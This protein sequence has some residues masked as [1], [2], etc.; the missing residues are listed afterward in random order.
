MR[1]LV[2]GVGL[3]G[4]DVRN[5][6]RD[7]EVTHDSPSDPMG[8]DCVVVVVASRPALAVAHDLDRSG[9]AFLPVWGHHGRLQIGPLVAP[10]GPCFECFEQRERQHASELAVHDAITSHWLRAVVPAPTEQLRALRKIA[11][12][13]I[14][15][16]KETVTDVDRVPEELI[17]VVRRHPHGG[18]D[19][20]E[21]RVVAMHGCKCAAVSV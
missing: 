17:G 3:Y 15:K 19:V 18:G 2:V 12:S 1:V 14:A 8:E 4:R 11:A 13:E 20:V 9:Q 7:R 5:V 21:G 6:L 16:L 10:G